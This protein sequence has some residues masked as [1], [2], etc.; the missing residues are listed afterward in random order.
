MSHAVSCEQ[1][2][3]PAV[4]ESVSALKSYLSGR[5]NTN[6]QMRKDLMLVYHIMRALSG[7]CTWLN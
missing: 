6:G 5:A 3:Q 7:I 4:Y 2:L 1:R